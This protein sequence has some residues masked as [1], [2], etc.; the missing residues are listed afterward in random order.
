MFERTLKWLWDYN[1]TGE[2][3]SF[4]SNMEDANL[5]KEQMEKARN[6]FSKT[7][8]IEG[9]TPSHRRQ[10]EFQSMLSTH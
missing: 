6:F 4:M 3:E 2:G 1:I 9:S 8:I 5:L 10:T 7:G